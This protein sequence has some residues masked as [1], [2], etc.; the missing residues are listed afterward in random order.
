VHDRFKPSYV[1]LRLQHAP[2]NGHHLRELKALIEFE[3]ELWAEAMSLFFRCFHEVAR[4]SRIS[5]PDIL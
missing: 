3:R 1:Q 5:D 2:G 4:R